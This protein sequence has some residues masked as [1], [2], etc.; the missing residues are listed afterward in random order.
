[1]KMCLASVLLFPDLAVR[2]KPTELSLESRVA[3]LKL[4]GPQGS[5]RST[6]K[7]S[8]GSCQILGITPIPQAGLRSRQ[9]TAG[10]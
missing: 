7:A 4:N 6:S 8:V 10:D 2:Q 3:L 5:L 9:T 1:M